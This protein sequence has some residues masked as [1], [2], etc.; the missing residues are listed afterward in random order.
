M[1]QLLLRISYL[2]FALF[3]STFLLAQPGILDPSFGNG[4]KVIT[5]I[6]GADA[7]AYSVVITSAGKILAGG[8]S[9]INNHEQFTLI[10]Y[11]TGGVI[12]STFGT[13]G[14][15]VT[16]INTRSRINNVTLQ[17]DGKI[18]AGGY[19]VDSPYTST[20]PGPFTLARY[21]ANGS[22]DTSFGNGG[23]AFTVFPNGTANPGINKIL[24]KPDG[25]ILA[26]GGLSAYILDEYSALA[27]YL[28]NGSI[29]SSFGTNGMLEFA[30][31]VF[32]ADGLW[33]TDMSLAPDGKIVAAIRTNAVP[34][35]NW[36][37]FLLMRFLPNGTIDNSFGPYGVLRTDFNGN[38]DDAR[39]VVVLPD[40][41]IIAAGWGGATGSFALA[42]YRPNGTL[43]NSFGTGGKVSTPMISAAIGNHLFVQPDGRIILTG[44]T[45]NSTEDFAIVS[46]NSNGSLNTAFGNNGVVTTDFLGYKDESFCS[47]LQADGKIVLAGY[48]KDAG[49]S[50]IA[51]SRYMNGPLPLTLLSFTAFKENKTNHIKWQTAQEQKTQSFVVERATG[52]TGFTVL[53]TL[54]AAGNSTSVN[55]YSFIDAAP[56]TATNFYRLKMVDKDGKFTYSAIRTV[57]NNSSLYVSLY[58]NPAKEKLNLQVESDKK[59]LLQIQVLTLHGKL[60]LSKTLNV[61]AGTSTTPIDITMF[62]RSGYF[63]KVMLAGKEEMVLPFDKL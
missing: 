36:G 32:G 39:C 29:D 10:Q 44:L 37:D 24:V 1:K 4:G 41:S 27:Q 60:M 11:N 61:D 7:T 12:D 16:P 28:P 53:G 15:V 2:A 47:A 23:L 9:K 13:N 58:P 31:Y 20:N 18:L 34:V 14:I 25:K 51:L 54:N 45:F 22:L 6:N 19:S 38:G 48:A 5:S 55:N 35:V 40:S 56:L 49:K 50:N 63:L 26:G 62:P 3:T 17:P 21:H 8:A 43:D 57:N 52:Q 30:P 46:Y 42:K 33:L 59:A